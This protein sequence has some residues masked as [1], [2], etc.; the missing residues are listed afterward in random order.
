[1]NEREA[2]PSTA[3][4]VN[5]PA[6][7]GGA[8]AP[9]AQRDVEK[10][11]SAASTKTEVLVDG[12][13]SAWPHYPAAVRGGG[14]VFVSGVRGGRP[15]FAPAS[16]AEL[17]EAL[18]DWAQGYTIVDALEGIVAADSWAAHDNM[19]RILDAAQ[20]SS[21]QVLRQRMWQRDKRYFPIYERVRKHWQPEAAPSSGLGVRSVGGRFGRWIG[22]ESIAVD[23]ADPHRLGDRITVSP[24]DDKRHP[25]AS[26]Y[27][28]A[29]ASGPLVF[30]AGHIPI[31]TAE[32]GN[33]LVASFDD[34]PPDGRFLAIGRS[35]PD[36][37][38]GPIAAQTWYVYNEISRTLDAHGMTIADIVHVRVY[39][40]DLR[41][42]ATFHRVHEHIFGDDAPALCVV[43]F[44]EVG[45][46]GCRIEIEPTVLRPGRAVRAATDWTCP[47]PTAGPA[48]MRAG[49][50]VFIAGMCGLGPDGHPA[51][52]SGSVDREARDLVRSLEASAS[53]PWV[54]AQVWW[55]WRRLAET[56][57]AAGTSL[58]SLTKTVV[59]LRDES[60]LPVYEAVRSMFV[61]T[62]LPAF[63]CVIVDGP[64]PSTEIAVQIDAVALAAP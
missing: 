36:S 20:T 35:H 57:D 41:D 61:E 9:V 27:S 48:A 34:V 4:V 50:L 28:Q 60:D 52:D 15:G 46:K 43:G 17:P 21:T 30:M 45:H 44:D 39:L 59:Y 26:I 23:A 58:D 62:R 2:S 63:D 47:A 8:D 42:L 12:E 55:A 16:Y 64:G 32:P 40:S 6:V 13:L 49:P 25:S 33:P 22:I 31:R 29:V 5:R 19:E 11:A 3:E 53:V 24:P 54:P 18:A 56:C 14:F 38:D 7:Q 51:R 10:A 1:M 37:R